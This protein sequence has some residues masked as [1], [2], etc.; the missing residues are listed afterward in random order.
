MIKE[1]S[2]EKQKPRFRFKSSIRFLT[3]G[4]IIGIMLS[5]SLVYSGSL[6]SLIRRTPKFSDFKASFSDSAE[7]EITI[8]YLKKKLENI[9]ELSTAEMTYNGLF[10]VTEGK[11]PF[12]TKKG[13]S[14][15]YK[16]TVKAGIDASL[17]NIEV[18]DDKIIVV[19][20]PTIIH[21]SWVDPDSIRF[22]DEKLAL[23]NWS[24]K[25][26]VTQAISAAEKDVKEKADT[27][28]LLDRA[29]RQAEYI[30][31]GIIEST[32]G[33]RKVVIM[34]WNLLV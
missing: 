33:K 3:Y 12:I 7:Q 6:N 22:Y 34:H 24:E 11:I 16:A 27:D 32:A 23:F 29:T 8:E 13:F 2:K 10:T 30:T 25:N 15:I 26:D 31:K 19:L 5:L 20:P 4:I 28:G 18:T 17:I 9:S 1:N 14:M 21:M